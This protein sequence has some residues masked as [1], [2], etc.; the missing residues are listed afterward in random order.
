MKKRLSL[1]EY[2]D[3]IISGNRMILSRAITL[4][5]SNLPSDK[6]LAQEVIEAILPHTGKSVRLGI[7]SLAPIYNRGGNGLATVSQIYFSVINAK[8][9]H[10]RLQIGVSRVPF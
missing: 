4:I 10:T 6:K 5:E 1:S 8:P 9:I 7:T 3:G 2:T